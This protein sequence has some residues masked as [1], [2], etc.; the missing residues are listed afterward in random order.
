MRDVVAVQQQHVPA[1]AQ[2]PGV[3]L[4]QG[5]INFWLNALFFCARRMPWVV[6]GMR[7]AVVRWTGRWSVQIRRATALNARR[8][9]RSD[10]TDEQCDKFGGQVVGSFAD[11]VLDVARATTQTPE[12]I[13]AR[14][15]VVEGDEHYRAARALKRGA[16][17]VT[18]H[19]GSFE[20]GVA[21][22]R[23]YEPKIHIVFQRDAMSRF[24]QIRTELR[25]KLGVIEAPID[26]GWSIWLKLRD[27]L[28]A[29]EVVLIQGDRV[30]PGQ[31]G[32]RVEFLGH[33]ILLP[34]GPARLALAT[35]SPILPIFSIRQPD[36]RIR[37]V[38][39]E[40][41]E[42]RNGEVEQAMNAYA[43]ALA[44]HVAAH[45]QQW[46]RLQPVFCED[47]GVS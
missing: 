32:E 25:R 16:I 12:Q 9:V 22:L 36:G 18:A 44:K 10:L 7:P 4:R 35:G 27:A 13:R 38:V 34:T 43:R 21:A 2:R 40:A 26:D 23:Q 28:L 19:M 3:S 46:L 11:F 15:A 31:K 29:D 30:M 14:I 20:V 5:L 24:E 37:L 1:D 42:V 17:V 8:I 47:N 39:E 6:R 33:H 41:I 45:P